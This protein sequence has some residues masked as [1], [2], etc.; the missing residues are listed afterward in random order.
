MEYAEYVRKQYGADLNRLKQKLPDFLSRE[1]GLPTRKHFRCLNPAHEDRHPSMSYYAAGQCVKCFSCGFTADLLTTAGLYWGTSDEKE[2]I[3]RLLVLYPD[4]CELPQISGYLRRRGLSESIIRWS[5]AVEV[6]DV[7]LGPA[8]RLPY[9]QGEYAVYRAVSNK[10]FRKP[11][12]VPE[13]VCFPEFLQQSEPIF[14]VEA[15]IC[16]L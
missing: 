7:L 12:G 9:H 6:N 15:Y 1:M 14:L 16:A 3:P 2:I 10:R 13:P 4:C 11:A 5:G 8:V